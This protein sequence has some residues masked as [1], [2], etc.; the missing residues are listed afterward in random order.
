MDLREHAKFINGHVPNG[1]VFCSDC[2]DQI[3]LSQDSWAMLCTTCEK[4]GYAEP[5]LD[6]N[7]RLLTISD[8]GGKRFYATIHPFVVS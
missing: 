5:E 4:N 8:A 3:V 7:D 2:G 6:A 1:R